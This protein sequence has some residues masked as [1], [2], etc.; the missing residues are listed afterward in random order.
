M[1]TMTSEKSK[2]YDPRYWH[3]IQPPEEID[4]SRQ[5][6][7]DEDALSLLRKW[8]RLDE[9]S[10][11][12]IVEVGCGSGYFTGKLLQM[13]TTLRE[14]VAI[15]PDEVLREYARQK[16]LR[17]VRFVKGTAEDVP[18]PNGFSDLTV[19][20]IVLNILPDVYRAV[21]EMARITKSGGIVAAIEPGGGGI[22][23]YPDPK[24][25]EMEEVFR[26]A[27]GKGIWDLRRELMDYSQEL[28]QK[29]AR[30]A[31]VFHSVGLIDVEAHGILSVFLLSDPR[32]NQK[33]IINWLG[34]R[35]HIHENS[36]ERVR[37]IVKRGRLLESLI[38]EYYEAKKAYLSNLVRH[39]EQIPKTHELQTTSRVVTVGFK[40]GS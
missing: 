12:T 6:E 19:C 39:P 1:T 17:R 27:Y 33:E 11:K 16:H 30:Y 37:T 13:T 15:E 25:N 8:L 28:K 35:L 18:L 10:P 20:H 40:P 34:K 22:S 3:N 29:R 32:Y 23:Y 31:E 38:Q 2:E 7:Y 24:L 9:A 36:R 4:V 14:M 26:K 5:F 21:S